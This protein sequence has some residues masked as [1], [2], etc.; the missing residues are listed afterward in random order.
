[1]ARIDRSSLVAAALGGGVAVLA[2]WQPLGAAGAALAGTLVAF[3]LYLGLSRRTRARR[4]VLERPFPDEWRTLL[5]R[6]VVYY[7]ELDERER[8]RFRQ[9]VACF[10]AEQTITGPRGAP[11]DD[12]LRLLCASA[13]VMLVFGRPGFRYPVLRD[14]VVYAAAFDEEDFQVSREG[15]FE[16]Q[17]HTQGPI[18]LS[19][20]ALR[21][22]FEDAYD[23]RNVALH[24]FAHVLDY[25]KGESDGVPIFMPAPIVEE[26]RELTLREMERASTGRS[27]LDDYAAESEAELFAVA[28]EAFFERPRGLRRRHPELYALLRQTY[29][30]DP[31]AK[32][33]KT[34]KRAE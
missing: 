17:V 10:L 25:E 32:R 34:R 33:F 15:D 9:E 30:Q 31:A 27:V 12:E 13:A 5:E 24:E 26:W 23:G 2:S 20:E 19:A 28:T 22:G 7:R 29:Q 18:L 8:G 3:A 1:M 21:E 6:R 11:L 16:G 14:I 4:R